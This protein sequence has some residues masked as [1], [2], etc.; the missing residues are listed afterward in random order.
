M[1]LIRLEL[2]P[3]V[4]YSSINSI[5]LLL[6]EDLVEEETEEVLVIE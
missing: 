1:S 5:L 4:C 2:L 3:R 6:L